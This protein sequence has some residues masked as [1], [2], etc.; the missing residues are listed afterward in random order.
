M[1]PIYNSIYSYFSNGWGN[2][3]NS[4]IYVMEGTLWTAADTVRYAWKYR[5]KDRLDSH[6]YT[7]KDYLFTDNFYVAKATPEYSLRAEDAP[8]NYIDER[9]HPLSGDFAYPHFYRYRVSAFL[10][11]NFNESDVARAVD[12]WRDGKQGSEINALAWMFDIYRA[13]FPERD[14]LD[15]LKMLKAHMVALGE[16]SFFGYKE[17]LEK[18]KTLPEILEICGV[19]S[20]VF[21]GDSLMEPGQFDPGKAMSHF[22]KAHLMGMVARE[23]DVLL[24]AEDLKTKGREALAEIAA[25]V[26]DAYENPTGD[27]WMTVDMF[28]AGRVLGRQ[29]FSKRISELVLE[30]VR[31]RGDIEETG[32][33]ERM[34]YPDQ[35]IFEYLKHVYATKSDEEIYGM[36]IRRMNRESIEFQAAIQELVC[37]RMDITGQGFTAGDY[38]EYVKAVKEYENMPVFGNNAALDRLDSPDADTVFSAIR[39]LIEM[40]AIEKNEHILRSIALNL[41]D[42]SALHTPAGGI[43]FVVSPWTLRR[44]RGVL[45]MENEGD[46]LFGDGGSSLIV[47]SDEINNR[48][49]AILAKS[50]FP[51]GLKSLESVI[52]EIEKGDWNAFRFE[53][54]NV[55]LFGIGK[56]DNDEFLRAYVDKMKFGNNTAMLAHYL[57]RMSEL[58]GRHISFLKRQ[59]EEGFQKLGNR[60]YTRHVMLMEERFLYM[61]PLIRMMVLDPKLKM[62]FLG[63][64]M[65]P[66]YNTLRILAEKLDINHAADSS[67]YTGMYRYA[68][69]SDPRNHFMAQSI[70]PML[71]KEEADEVVSDDLWD[72]IIKK[73]EDDSIADRLNTELKEIWDEEGGLSSL[74]KKKLKR[75][76]AVVLLANFGLDKRFID[77]CVKVRESYLAAAFISGGFVVSDKYQVNCLIKDMLGTDRA[78]K[79]LSEKNKRFITAGLQKLADNDENVL[80]LQRELLHGYARVFGYGEEVGALK[81]NIKHEARSLLNVLLEGTEMSRRIKSASGVVCVDEASVSGISLLLTETVA[82]CFKGDSGM[83]YR[84]H[85]VSQRTRDTDEHFKAK[86]VLNSTSTSGIWPQEDTNEE[87]LGMYVEDEAREKKFLT[88]QE[89]SVEFMTHQLEIAPEK[90][91]EDLQSD[92]VVLNSMIDEYITERALFGYIDSM[93]S[94]RYDTAFIKREFFKL[95]MRLD[96]EDIRPEVR[97]VMEA[98]LINDLARG[99]TVFEADSP[100]MFMFKDAIRNYRAGGTKGF[101]VPESIVSLD[102]KVWPADMCSHFARYE[103]R[104]KEMV[105]EYAGIIPWFEKGESGG[106]NARA[107]V[108]GTS[109][110]YA[111]KKYFYKNCR[112]DN[113]KISFDSKKI[114]TGEDGETLYTVYRGSGD[115]LYVEV[116]SVA[117][118]KAAMSSENGDI[119]QAAEEAR[120]R[121]EK[122]NAGL[123]AFIRENRTSSEKNILELV[124]IAGEVLKEKGPLLVGAEYTDPVFEKL[125]L[126]PSFT[127]DTR[128]ERLANKVPRPLNVEIPS[129][130]PGLVDE[131]SR[132][133]LLSI[134]QKTLHLAYVR[135]G[136]SEG[137]RIFNLGD[138][139]TRA[140]IENGIIFDVIEELNIDGPISLHLGWAIKD[141]EAVYKNG[142]E[143]Q[144]H[145]MLDENEAFNIIVQNIAVF[146]QK[147]ED[148]GLKNKL[149]L[150]NGGYFPGVNYV[151]K[152]DFIR[153]IADKTECGF[154]IDLGHITYTALRGDSAITGEGAD[155]PI[156]YLKKIIDEETVKLL[157]EVHVSVPWFDENTRLWEHSGARGQPQAS[158]HEN[159][160]G[161]RMVK[162]LLE[163]I[164][165]LR[166]QTGITK[167]YPL[168]VNFETNDDH[169]REEIL[170]LTV[171]LKNK[172]HIDFAAKACKKS[173]ET[174]LFVKERLDWNP[175]KDDKDFEK[176]KKCRICGSENPKKT[177]IKYS[178]DGREFEVLRCE[179]DGYMW[180]TPEPTEEAAKTKL[181]GDSKYFGEGRRPL[182]EQEMKDWHNRVGYGYRFYQQPGANKIRTQRN[183]DRINILLERKGIKKDDR[184]LDLG[185]SSGGFLA[186]LK[187]SDVSPKNLYANEISKNECEKL[188]ELNIIHEDHIFPGKVEDLEVENT[189]KFDVITA[190]DVLEHSYNPTN[191]LKKV[192]SM[193]KSNGHLI[194]S[195]P[196]CPAKGPDQFKSLEHISYFSVETLEKILKDNGFGTIDIFDKEG[197]TL[198]GQHFGAVF[199]IARIGEVVSRGD[200]KHMEE[201]VAT[202]EEMEQ[203]NEFPVVAKVVDD[204]TGESITAVSSYVDEIKLWDHSE[205]RALKKAVKRG[206]D[207]SK[208]TLYVTEENCY[209]CAKAATTC[210]RAGRIVI[211]CDD[212]NIAKIGKTITKE[213]GIESES[214][215]NEQLSARV[216]DMLSKYKE[217]HPD[218]DIPVQKEGENKKYEKAARNPLNTLTD[219]LKKTHIHG[220]TELFDWAGYCFL[221]SSDLK[222]MSEDEQICTINA[223]VAEWKEGED[224]DKNAFKHFWR[225]A[226]RVRPQNS[227]IKIVL[228]GE[229]EKCSGMK[230][231]IDAYLRKNPAELKKLEEKL[232][233]KLSVEFKILTENM[234]SYLEKRKLFEFKNKRWDWK[235]GDGIMLLMGAPFEED[236]RQGL[237]EIL[238]ELRGKEKDFLKL[239]LHE[240]EHLHITV[241]E[242]IPNTKNV[243][244]DGGMAA[245]RKEKVQKARSIVAK[246]MLP[247]G[248]RFYYK[249][250]TLNRNGDIIAL[251]YA[252]DNSLSALRDALEKE[253]VS[254]KRTNIV[255]M[256]I[257][258]IM[259]ENITPEQFDKYKELIKGLRKKVNDSGAPAL[260]CSIN[261]DELRFWDQ[262]G[263]TDELRYGGTF[264]PVALSCPV[265]LQMLTKEFAAKHSDKLI[266][267]QNTIPNVN[268]VAGQLLADEWKT[269]DDWKRGNKVFPAKW[270]HSIVAVNGKGDPVG[271]LLAYERP[272]DIEMENIG[273]RSLYIHGFARDSKYKGTGIG[274]MMMRKMAKNLLENGYFQ[275]KADDNPVITLKF[276]KHSPYLQKVYEELG[277]EYVGRKMT[278]YEEGEN[279]DDFI[280]AGHAID[281]AVFPLYKSDFARNHAQ[282]VK[283]IALLLAGSL[284]VSEQMIRE[285]SIACAIH[286]LD[287]PKKTE[288]ISPE[289]EERVRKR[290]NEMGIDLPKWSRNVDEYTG[291]IK[292]FDENEDEFTRE[293]KDCVLDIYEPCAALGAAKANGIPVNRAIETAV[294]FH[295]HIGELEDYL[296]GMKDRSKD[297]KRDTITIAS[298]LV[299][300]DSIEKGMNLFKRIFL[301][302]TTTLETP[303]ET[304][305]YLS[306]KSGI[307]KDMCDEI[308]VA[309]DKVKDS[310][311]FKKIAEDAGKISDKEWQDLKKVGRGKILSKVLYSPPEDK[312][313]KI[314]SN[315]IDIEKETDSEIADEVT[316]LFEIVAGVMN[317]RRDMLVEKANSI[318]LS[319]KE[320]DS[321][322]TDVTLLSRDT[323]TSRLIEQLRIVSC[324]GSKYMEKEKIADAVN[325]IELNLDLLETDSIVSNIIIRA[326]KAARRGKTVTVAFD[327]SWIPGFAEDKTVRDIVN[328]VVSRLILLEEALR[329]MDLDNV[330]VITRKWDEDKIKHEPVETWIQR[331]TDNRVVPG[332]FS[333]VMVFGGMEAVNHFDSKLE[334]ENISLRNR[335]FLAGVDPSGLDK[336]T[337]LAGYYWDL[338]IL[339]M[340]SDAFE[341]FAGKNI[342]G[343]QHIDKTR[344]NLE[345]KLLIF[346]PG[347]EIKDIGLIIDKFKA[348][349]KALISV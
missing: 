47:M 3:R 190:F 257:G 89:L 30:A 63:R 25:K 272:A 132:N 65:E 33:L 329:S 332:D 74:K 273:K 146:K 36:I 278:V 203:K 319:L 42:I 301:D 277:F 120:A 213:L 81:G 304:Q 43:A 73:A 300:A 314:E 276:D 285:I 50:L 298:L 264:E 128:K 114:Y 177:G 311:E 71:T 284:G 292:R 293:E 92:I 119:R 192:K 51:E 315:T 242:L 41:R 168:I 178:V 246:Y 263:E 256:T 343:T 153:R 240:P 140:Q 299:A 102:M 64:G 181:Y 340:L 251:G 323:V 282:R 312:K 169:A 129:V 56:S 279:H 55:I 171:M 260:L 46:V 172:V 145:L 202:A 186:A 161:V 167:T 344:S 317:N 137:K 214:I 307:P 349:R 78:Q 67:I 108:N 245:K 322:L 57:S 295:H 35:Q 212:P 130:H 341:A 193:L 77:Y 138:S 225:D 258:R 187:K 151:L 176:T 58:S 265:N 335:A 116:F 244:Q 94:L 154:L 125:N 247:L 194:M 221:K 288:H 231:M 121:V 205:M 105:I 68:D 69:H 275:M 136:D 211:G 59:I 155:T 44:L 159:T 233:S 142:S 19:S 23:A 297:E 9:I 281:I 296:D 255:H 61:L 283:R 348:K 269:T 109:D 72:K 97:S 21:K 7:D 139:R 232:G 84:T 179:K 268:W 99:I 252:N 104:A 45:G 113:G 330:Y 133:G 6:E 310:P 291:F 338:E 150:E 52:E 96:R 93:E 112:P 101:S 75:R 103:E 24:S 79:Y 229:G 327:F 286:D 162:E 87:F 253:G 196:C 141:F 115:N 143:G 10:D 308:L 166:E 334:K 249:D 117:G 220:D 262:A 250:L 254:S 118:F 70:I 82:R 144:E 13:A 31:E 60:M 124:R 302:K 88:F 215:N 243:S 15:V 206:W 230:N 328:P 107:F 49:R 197:K 236:A 2:A 266:K 22:I 28:P 32:Y 183:I 173:D 4:R 333:D 157:G 158:F 123:N 199:F 160:E 331:V 219:L 95:V 12:S 216:R 182:P 318:I 127:V 62:I 80:A 54:N 189:D 326:R 241:A 306:N 8:L 39:E 267:L 201:I 191:F 280:Y 210:L 163:Y 294:L 346:L 234:L 321:A 85:N 29:G 111:M 14:S 287:T 48:S 1:A 224:G 238:K 217:K 106:D 135:T 271:L 209:Y 325:F 98:V 40:A 34:S 195:V 198:C 239:Y 17:L 345:K 222:N 156:N 18:N 270:D 248:V 185:A 38:R 180:I 149:L 324:E 218:D 336:N 174:F 83:A 131:L 110:F 290:F 126:I 16:L 53:G 303:D 261:A 337:L 200:E 5:F 147:M 86:G 227:K 11:E 188:K 27:D 223:N 289:A 305:K 313:R 204:S 175:F 237:E 164:I 309:F 274:A 347:A 90:S 148:R 320:H 122:E 91:D 100:V 316:K 26:S 342:S 259:D 208:C 134:P 170:A 228:I 76:E 66:F 20:L 165:D 207:M 184:V 226:L 37:E 235:K 339:K 152:H